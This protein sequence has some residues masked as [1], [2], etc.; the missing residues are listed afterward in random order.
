MDV[1]E[2]K[3]KVFTRMVKDRMDEVGLQYTDEQAEQMGDFVN[4]VV[5]VAKE[6]M[7]D[8]IINSIKEM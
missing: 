3:I 5:M 2:A 7:K 8:N 1:K 6:I 4:G